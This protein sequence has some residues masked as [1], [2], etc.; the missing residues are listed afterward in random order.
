MSYILRGGKAMWT[1]GELKDRAKVVLKINYWKSFGMSLV[2]ALCVANINLNIRQNNFFDISIGSV[3]RFIIDINPSL[4]FLTVFVAILLVVIGLKI[5]LGYQFEVGGRKYFIQSAQYKDN[6]EC[7]KF[8]FNG[9]NYNAIL[10]TMFLRSIYLILWTLLLIFPGIIQYYAYRM[11]PYIL[12]DNPNI[13][14]K[15]AIDLSSDMMEGNKFKLFVLELSFW[16]WYLLGALAL[17]VGML[18]VN[19]Y[20]D[21]TVAELYLELREHAI[22]NDFCSY[23]DLMLEQIDKDKDI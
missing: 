9:Q 7:F 21:A 3:S 23:E 19:P 8:A 2:I 13:G 16:G 15:I 11:V 12:A 20:V 14:A 4:N 18:F 22:E 1:R 10:K 17:F 6:Q 5:F